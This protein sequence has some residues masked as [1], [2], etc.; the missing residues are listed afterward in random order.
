[1]TWISVKGVA[2]SPIGYFGTNYSY[3]FTTNTTVTMTVNNWQSVPKTSIK[4][5]GGVSVSSG[6]WTNSAIDLSA[7]AGQTVQVGFHFQSGPSGW[8]NAPGWYVDDVSLAAAP[9]INGPTNLVVLYGQKLTNT[10]SATNIYSP[11]S[12]FN[13]GLVPPSTNGVIK[14]N[15]VLIWTN[16]AAPPGTYAIVVAVTD[17]SLLLSATNNFTVT[18]LPLPS[19]LILTNALSGGRGFRLGVKTPWTNNTWRIEAAT[20]LNTSATNWLPVFTNMPGSGGT[21]QFTDRLATNYLQ[22]FYR[23]VYP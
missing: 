3:T 12:T 14:S 8:G 18:V 16:T 4:G 7:Y 11:S 17:N 10:I 22:R 6:G 19:Q 20:N 1:M 15:S 9:V 2:D 13:F 21:L 5:V 23:A